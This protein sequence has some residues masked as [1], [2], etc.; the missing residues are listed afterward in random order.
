MLRALL[1]SGLLLVPACPHQSHTTPENAPP[2]H[3]A[4]SGGPDDEVGAFRVALANPSKFPIRTGLEIDREALINA[5]EDFRRHHEELLTSRF[6]ASVNRL[7][8]GELPQAPS[9]KPLCTAGDELF[10]EDAFRLLFTYDPDA[11]HLARRALSI[12]LPVAMMKDL[13]L[14]HEQ[15]GQ[16]LGFVDLA[17]P[18][19]RLCRRTADTITVCIDYGSLDVF[20]IDLKRKGHEWMASSMTWWQ[21]T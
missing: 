10:G 12:S 14:T 9:Y 20:A 17:T 11:V 16:W 3:S 13:S 7:P 4:A 2:T 5:V 6:L 19:H 15:I 18:T 1:L 21:K 8:Q